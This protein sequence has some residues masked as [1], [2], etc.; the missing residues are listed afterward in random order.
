VVYE[1]L[2]V[3]RFTILGGGEAMK[4]LIIYVSGPYSSDTEEGRLANTINAIQAGIGV[5]QK[6]HY[7][8]IPHLSHFTDRYARDIMR[9]NFT[10][11]QWMAQ[12][13]AFLEKCDAILYLA[14]SKGA[15]IE[16]AKAKELGLQVFY[17][18]DEVPSV[19][20]VE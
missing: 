4:P 14:S 8:L 19:E 1:K 16:L 17:S 15:D 5:M 6:G 13:L 3:R 7:S 20:V 11:E 18:L 12:D 2:E 10:W 9:V